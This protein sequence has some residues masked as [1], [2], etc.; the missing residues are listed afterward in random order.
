MRIVFFN[1]FFWPDAIATSQLLTDL[2]QGAATDHDITVIC[3]GVGVVQAEDERRRCP[4]V[5]ILRAKNLKFGHGIVNR[6]A[7]YMTF[8]TGSTF[9]GM[10]CRRPDVIVTLTTPPI[11]AVIGSVLSSLRSCNHVIWEMDVY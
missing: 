9:F 8:T 5:T 1:Q 3:G 2:A 7:S 10:F 11:L 6:L 4:D